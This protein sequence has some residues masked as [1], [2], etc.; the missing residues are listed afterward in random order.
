MN[1]DDPLAGHASFDRGGGE[2][3]GG[4][5]PAPS[6][7]D[8]LAG[9][10]SFDR[11]AS[12]APPASSWLHTA[13]YGAQ[14]L[15]HG[16]VQ[17]IGLPNMVGHLFAAATD[18][19]PGFAPRRSL[20]DVGGKELP[21][22]EIGYTPQ[23]VEQAW[24][25]RGFNRLS[26]TGPIEQAVGGLARGTG[27]GVATLPLG[28]MGAP[29]EA[30]AMSGA[31]GLGGQLAEMAVPDSSWAPLVGGMIG[32]LSGGE[33][34]ARLST[35]ASLRSAKAELARTTAE[36]T[37]LEAQQ[38]EQGVANKERAFEAT[39]ALRASHDAEDAALKKSIAAS[40]ALRDQTIGD[41]QAQI[42]QSK[43]QMGT[44]LR[45]IDEFHAL[46]KG[47]S[48]AQGAQDLAQA[49]AAL[50]AS[51]AKRTSSTEPDPIGQVVQ[52]QGRN[53]LSATLPSAENEA[54]GPV[55]ELMAGEPTPLEAF[56]DR[57][58]RI[59]GR[60]GELKDL[61]ARFAPNIGK[62]LGPG[63]EALEGVPSWGD[64]RELR[65][66]IG[67]AKGNPQVLRDIGEQNLDS[68]YQAAT[69]D[70]RSAAAAKGPEAALAFEQANSTS[71]ELR[72]FADGPIARLVKGAKPTSE[73][74][75]PGKL[76][77]SLLSEAKQTSATLGAL[78]AQP[79]TA[80]AVDKLAGYV[81]HQVKGGDS[82]AWT[83]LVPSAKVALVPDEAERTQ[84]ERA[85]ATSPREFDSAPFE[86]QKQSV[87]AAHEGRV[88]AAKGLIDQANSA[89]VASVA[90]ARGMAQRAKLAATRARQDLLAQQ[91]IEGARLS[92]TISG[93]RAREA[94][95]RA[96]AQR[97][98]SNALL[99]AGEALLS[100]HLAES[101]RQGAANML[102]YTG[103]APPAWLTSL[104]GLTAPS[105][106]RAGSH[107]LAH[108][109]R[110]ARGALTG[111]LTNPLTPSGR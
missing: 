32:A 51:A 16:A 22:G 48:E 35:L 72:D 70:L 1:D 111:A 52:A 59:A 2:T 9:H 86:A 104:I 105:L 46:L 28:G 71:R 64:V 74:L 43:V 108:P 31:A 55:N 80:Q 47:Q 88:S 73:D 41:A 66:A 78:R 68:L 87:Q 38:A 67:E 50:A 100:E 101:M 106:I 90:D 24:Q 85:I 57:A 49:R 54:W 30:I 107:I 18:L 45:R 58:Q 98:P 7:E 77:N 53:F 84:I 13:G 10:P 99:H 95:L 81:L 76:V 96:Q 19:I 34:A 102:G 42:A 4:S 79:A 39:Q 37:A 6:L 20:V 65:S 21:S 89:H 29:A 83:E 26:P 93:V 12:A 11:G 97:P 61:V 5:L 36:R 8:P 91:G 15:A 63:L 27:L 109:A 33:A 25:N 14:E 17:A 75:A 62:V 110:G 3:A 94:A 56:A 82:K 69:E 92:A 40:Q 103:I 44:E 60:G 23:E